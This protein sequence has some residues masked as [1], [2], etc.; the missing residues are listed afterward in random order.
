MILKK[1]RYSKGLTQSQVAKTLG[2]S[3][4]FYR[5]IEAGDRKPSYKNLNKLE[6][7]FKLPQRVLLAKSIE[8]VPDFYKPYLEELEKC[9]K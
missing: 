9:K 3:E 8:E 5:S 6:D 1:I 7:L 4:R 2:V